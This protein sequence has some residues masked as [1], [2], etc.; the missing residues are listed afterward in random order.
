[1]TYTGKLG[2]SREKA[3]IFL[4]AFYGIPLLSKPSQLLASVDPLGSRVLRPLE[5]RLLASV[6]PLGS[7]VLRPLEQRL[8]SEYRSARDKLTASL[9][10]HS[11]AVERGPASCR[12]QLQDR[13]RE[14]YQAC[15][16]AQARLARIRNYANWVGNGGETAA[17][18]AGGVFSVEEEA[19]GVE[20]AEIS[21]SQ[22]YRLAGCLVNTLLV[23]CGPAD[24]EDRPAS[25]GTHCKMWDY[26]IMTS[27]LYTESLSPL[28]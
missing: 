13:V 15:F 18:A 10:I 12:K 17:I 19:A 22:L 2:A 26:I 4:G 14:R 6:D 5:Q 25:T 21:L 27:L 9:T 28:F 24:R 23:L 1:M 11:S 3:Q 20:F 16:L 7:R 8:L